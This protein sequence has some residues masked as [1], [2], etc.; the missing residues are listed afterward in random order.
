VN[1]FQKEK[2]TALCLAVV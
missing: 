1:T 2:Q